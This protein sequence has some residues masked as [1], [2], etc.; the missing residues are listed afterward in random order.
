MKLHMIRLFIQY[1]HPLY[2]CQFPSS[3]TVDVTVGEI[4][5]GRRDHLVLSFY[6]LL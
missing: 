1:A 3:N 5:E 4:D 6:S 2:Q